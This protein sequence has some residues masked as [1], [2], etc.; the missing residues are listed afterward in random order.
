VL[1]G[2]VLKIEFMIAILAGRNGAMKFI[3]RVILIYTPTDY[4]RTPQAPLRFGQGKVP[5]ISGSGAVA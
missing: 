3:I 4:L 2:M 1:S 5:C